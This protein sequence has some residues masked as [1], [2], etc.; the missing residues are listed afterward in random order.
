MKKQRVGICELCERDN[1]QLTV[2]HLTPREEGGAH[3]ETA[4]L[5]IPCHKQIHAIY[6]NEEL[7]I[8]LDTIPRLKDDEQIKKYIEWIRKQPSQT[9][10]KTKKSKEKR[11]KSSRF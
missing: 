9:L 8:R 1:V 7:A 10:I 5:C 11:S 3:L 2:H 6:T 4:L